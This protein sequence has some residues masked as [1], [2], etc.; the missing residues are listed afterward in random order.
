M[1]AFP[2]NQFTKWACKLM[3]KVRVPR[4]ADSTGREEYVDCWIHPAPFCL[5]RYINDARKTDKESS[6]S[7]NYSVAPRRNNCKFVDNFE[8]VKTQKSKDVTS[9]EVIS[10]ITTR[11]ITANEELFINYGDNYHHF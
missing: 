6:S 3:E 4:S 9:Y 10:V 7:S 2:V 5:M 11:N 8:T 1:M